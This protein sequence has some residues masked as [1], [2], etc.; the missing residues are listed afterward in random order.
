MGSKGMGLIA[1]RDIAP[2]TFIIEYVG[3]IVTKAQWQE[4]HVDTVS[5][6]FYVM[7]YNNDLVVDGTF[8]GNDAR[9]INHSCA[10]NSECA[11]WRVNGETR[12]GIFA[13][14]KIAKGD[15]IVY[16]YHFETTG[17]RAF[18]CLCGAPNCGGWIGKSN[19]GA[20][21]S[22]GTPRQSRRDHAPV[23]LL[24]DFWQERSSDRN[25]DG[26]LKTSKD[27]EMEAAGLSAGKIDWYLTFLNSSGT[28]EKSLA[29][30]ALH[31]FEFELAFIRKHRVFLPRTLSVCRRAWGRRILKQLPQNDLADGLVLANFLSDDRCRRCEK[32]GFLQWCAVCVKAFHSSCGL[33][34]SRKVGDQWTCADCVGKTPGFE[35]PSERGHIWERKDTL[36]RNKKKIWHKLSAIDSSKRRKL[37]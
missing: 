22:G 34:G 20:A 24:Y 27:V 5:R 6:H 29:F 37:N 13:T 23:D 11:K 30:L 25:D 14:N 35:S 8:K 31:M 28:A 3:E 15:E 21:T 12:L 17:N 26:T 33:S 7:E 36:W 10:P 16:D 4:R 32:P 18:K 9:L 19:G 2:D 1:T